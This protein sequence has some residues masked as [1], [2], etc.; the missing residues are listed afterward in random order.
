MKVFLVDD[1]P[2]TLRML[3]SL[4]PWE[5]MGLVLAGCARDGEEAYKMVLEEMP[6]IIITDIRMNHMDGLEL[7]EKVRKVSKNIKIILMSAYADFGYVKEGIRLGCSNY[8]LKP[9]DEEELMESLRKVIEEIRGKKEEEKVIDKSEEQLRMLELYKYMRSGHGFSKVLKYRKEFGMEFEHYFLMVIQ[10]DSSSINEY[11]NTSS[12]E[13]LQEKYILNILGEIVKEQFGKRM[14]AFNYEDD[15]WMIL[16][17][18]AVEEEVVRICNRMIETFLNE[19]ELHVMICFSHQGHEIQDLPLLYER[20]K[21]L[22]K[23]AFYIGEESILG[24]DYNCIGQEI[25]QVRKLGL[26]R[27][28]ERALKVYDIVHLKEIL[29][30][31]FEISTI[32]QPDGLYDIYEFC[33]KVLYFIKKSLEVEVSKATLEENLE[34]YNLSY[35]ELKKYDSLKELK[36]LMDD[37]ISFLKKISIGGVEKTFSKPVEESLK[38]IETNYNKNLSLEEISDTI[39]VSKNYFCY[40]FKREVGISPWNYLTQVRLKYAKQLLE[41]TD[42]KT[43]EIAFQVGYDNPSYFSKIFKKLENVTPNEYRESKR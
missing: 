17:E 37:A 7:V 34:L 33:S 13:I 3:Q 19:L 9:I 41:E 25:D 16:F 20:V 15:A 28:A 1:E 8:I 35:E 30:E 36:T 42:M 2:I 40:L 22:Q 23:Y 24:Y 31:A 21:S 5:E 39:A 14:L 4:I 6:D 43:Y 11:A 38:M 12:I 29:E 32:Y 26:I 18:E 10:E 27:E